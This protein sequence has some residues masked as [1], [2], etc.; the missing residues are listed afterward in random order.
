MEGSPVA[1][2]RDRIPCEGQPKPVLNLEHR[3]QSKSPRRG[4]EGICFLSR[5]VAKDRAYLASPGGSSLVSKTLVLGMNAGFS[6]R[7]M[8]MK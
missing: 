8:S 4:A 5:W 1:S 2:K 6:F 7:S 3:H